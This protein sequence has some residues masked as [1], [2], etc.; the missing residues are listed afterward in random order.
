MFTA[1]LAGLIAAFVSD[2][3]GQEIDIDG[4]AKK[5]RLKLSAKVNNAVE[6]AARNF[7]VD[8]EL[9]LA[10]IITESL[11]RPPWV[12]TIENALA[13]LGLKVTTGIA[14][15]KRG[16]STDVESV[17][18]LA[19]LYHDTALPGQHDV[20]NVKLESLL[21]RHNRSPEFLAIATDVFAALRGRYIAMSEDLDETNRPMIEVVS[22]VRVE[23][24]WLVRGT[25]ANDVRDIRLHDEETPHVILG[26][27]TIEDPH[28]YRR[29]WR[30]LVDISC[31]AGELS[32][33]QATSGHRL[34]L[35]TQ[36]NHSE[37]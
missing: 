9:L 22:S 30:M 11:Q 35:Y 32:G 33:V 27:A 14:Q 1:P 19:G 15:S 4:L 21:E 36:L 34:T 23:Q 3:G 20:L 10:I 31:W 16:R 24:N 37:G 18:T 12:R 7:R 17:A 2:R 25:C 5:E 13:R 26:M 8:R 28:N 6:S 29:P